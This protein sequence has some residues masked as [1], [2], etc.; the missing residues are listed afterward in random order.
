VHHGR[1]L[2]AIRA[3]EWVD[4]GSRTDVATTLRSLLVHRL[5]DLARFDEAFELFFRAH[6]SPSPG[7]PL[8][9]LG[10]RPRV[11]AQPAPG[12]PVPVDL[13][14]VQSESTA[15]SRAVGAWSAAGVSRTKDFGEYTDAELEAARRLLERLPWTVSVRRT[16]RWRRGASGA[17]PRGPSCSSATSADRWNGT[18]ECC[19]TL[20]MACHG[21][22]RGSKRSCSR[23]N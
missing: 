15:T 12:V 11:V 5:D 4:I 23:H 21:A 22:R 17:K 20:S 19:C 14:Q 6:R 10:E 9:S 13:E 16:R 8:F 1:L 2:D 18:A 3:L 7:L